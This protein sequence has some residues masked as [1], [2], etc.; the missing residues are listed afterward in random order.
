[1]IPPS[2]IYRCVNVLQYS[3][4]MGSESIK[5]FCG[6]KIIAICTHER[7]DWV[8]EC[9]RQ[10]TALLQQLV[11]MNINLLSFSRAR[12]VR[13]HA[14]YLGYACIS[15]SQP[16]IMHQH[17]VVMTRPALQGFVRIY[18]S[19]TLKS[20]LEF[21]ATSNATVNLRRETRK[22][23]TRHRARLADGDLYQKQ[24]VDTAHLKSI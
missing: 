13:V 1:M 11:L 22:A 12:K 14:V 6:K 8:E 2:N 9:C 4:V 5:P 16:A 23:H 20:G 18:A 3:Y 21:F 10:L 15:A 17:A 19:Q 24:L 7:G